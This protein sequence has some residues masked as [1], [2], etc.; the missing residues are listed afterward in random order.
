MT[1]SN[2][3]LTFVECWLFSLA[4]STLHA[5]NH[6]IFITAYDIGMIFYALK[7]EKPK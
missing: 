6:L 5:L 1:V 4:Q 7:K 2:N 3:M